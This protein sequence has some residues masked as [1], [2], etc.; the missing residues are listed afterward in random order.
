MNIEESLNILLQELEEKRIGTLEEL[1]RYTR[2]VQEYKEKLNTINERI[3]AI[4]SLKELCVIRK[5]N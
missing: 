5:L 4:Y 2:W 1:E 3:S